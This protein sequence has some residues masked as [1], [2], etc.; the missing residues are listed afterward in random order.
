MTR[1]LLDIR[2]KPHPVQTRLWGL[3]HVRIAEASELDHLMKIIETRKGADRLI[4]LVLMGACQ[5]D[6]RRA[7][8]IDDREKL[9]SAP[10]EPITELAT[11]FLEM[12]G[13]M[14]GVDEKK[15]SSPSSGS[16]SISPISSAIRSPG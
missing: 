4:E 15:S 1:S 9:R 8:G 12:N 3:C 6:G 13:I 11:A 7:F 10:L 14:G 5:S 2:L 16:P